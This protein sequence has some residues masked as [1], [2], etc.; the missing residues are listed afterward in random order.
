MV[1]FAAILVGFLLFVGLLGCVVPFIPGVWVA[2]AALWAVRLMGWPVDV[3]HLTAGGIA[4]LVVTVL[5]AVVPAW[6][7]KKF[8]CS[9][10][11]VWGCLAGSVVGAFFLPWGV[12][13]GP[14]L[15]TILGELSLGRDG[16]AAL[17][18]GI[19]A[20]L[21]F[22]FGVVIKVALCCLF[23]FWCFRALF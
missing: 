15:G 8:R 3:R 19:G 2:Y 18:S 6:G 20:L 9:R 14:F 4:A 7:A 11:G 1:V 16:N 13:L 5:D 23:S 22:L 10:R 12:L 21:G 17:V